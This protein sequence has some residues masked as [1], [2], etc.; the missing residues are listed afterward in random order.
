MIYVPSLDGR[1]YKLSASTGKI[2]WIYETEGTIS[3]SVSVIGNMM[4][5]GDSTGKVHGVD[6]ET[7]ENIWD[8]QLDGHVSS[9]PVVSDDT[10][11]VAT[12]NGSIYAIR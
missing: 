7:G 12:Q 3:E 8:M 9:T 6:T 1:V 11:Y 5:L 10:L 4:L 2:Q